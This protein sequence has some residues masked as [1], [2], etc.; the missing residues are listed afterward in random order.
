MSKIFKPRR[1]IA[2]VM[3]GSKAAT[4][5]SKGEFFMECPDTGVGTGKSKIKMGDGVTPYA[6]L[7]Y[8]IAGMDPDDPVE[9]ANKTYTDQT[10]ALND[11]RTGNSL[12]TV[13]NA[14]KSAVK[15]NADSV[16]ALNDETNQKLPFRLGVS[17]TTYGYYKNGSSTITPF[18]Q[19][20]GNAGA[21]QVLQ[22]SGANNTGTKY[23]ASNASSDGFAGSMVNRG[24]LNWSGNNT[25]ATV[26]A[27]Y[28][29]GGTLDSRPSYNSGY[30]NGYNA[31]VNAVKANPA[32]NGLGK[33]MGMTWGSFPYSASMSPDIG[34]WTVGPGTYRIIGDAEGRNDGA[35]EPKTTYAIGPGL[36]SGGGV[37][38]QVSWNFT[39]TLTA[40]ST[41]ITCTLGGHRV[42]YFRSGKMC[43]I[44]V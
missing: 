33:I 7:P 31:G 10:T 20:T 32:A 39:V 4:V 21:A 14:L 16:S 40:S 23:T 2:S 24:A 29:S 13:L 42:E 17:G 9:L 12:K 8:A 37:S 44:A 41:T 35:Y 27:G 34:T 15:L 3:R 18:R 28:Y 19:P 11:V 6:D 36:A 30:N 43:V 1:G 38:A 26:A 5:L 25:T 22:S